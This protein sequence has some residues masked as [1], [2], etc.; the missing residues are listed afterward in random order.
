[1]VLIAIFADRRPR[2]LASLLDE[3]L[4][5]SIRTTTRR[6][7]S[8]CCARSLPAPGC[9]LDGLIDSLGTDFDRQRLLQ[10]MGISRYQKNAATTG[11]RPIIDRSRM[12]LEG[13]T[14]T[15]PAISPGRSANGAVRRKKA[16]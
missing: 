12:S 7:T 5:A 3:L 1:L 4:C 6:P 16:P 13:A 8:V 15:T 14:S 10:V 9:D 2:R 11:L